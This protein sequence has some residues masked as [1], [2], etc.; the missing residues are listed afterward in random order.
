MK[1]FTIPCDFG[2]VKAPFHI[3]V[4]EPCA[5][6]DPLHYQAQ[7]LQTERGGAI[8]D[9]VIE[10]FKKLLAIAVENGVSFEELCV[11]ALGTA[12]STTK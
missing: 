9:E 2:G 12:S 3:Y 4:G 11:Y 7:W 6:E 8:P 5:D 10:S 1:R